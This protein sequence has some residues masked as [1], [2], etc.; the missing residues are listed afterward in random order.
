MIVARAMSAI[1]KGLVAGVIGT[2]AM[3]AS[4]SLEMR[5]RR[6]PPSTVPAEAAEKVLDVEP[7]TKRA[8]ERV[9]AAVHWAYGTGWGLV[10]GALGFAG[11][12][13]PLASLLHFAAVWGAALVTLP[14]MKLTPPP[15]EWGADEL[16]I[17]AW[18]H[19]VY[20]GAAG[21]AYDLLDRADPS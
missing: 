10:R 11:I 20:A 14:A 15:D 9:S 18:H 3:T 17:D 6:R 16:G 7:E 4:S 1:G 12:T 5:L 2:A 13:G 21:L 19:L 8:E